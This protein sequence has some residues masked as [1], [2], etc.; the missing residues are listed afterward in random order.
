VGIFIDKTGKPVGHSETRF[1]YMKFVLK[2]CYDY[3][4]TNKGTSLP[5]QTEGFY[6]ERHMNPYCL[7]IS[8]RN[9]VK[10]DLFATNRQRESFH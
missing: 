7:L 8:N 9:V 10:S 1:F 2:T 6:H 5:I 3:A 4:S